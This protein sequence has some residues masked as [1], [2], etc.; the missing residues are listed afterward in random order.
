MSDRMSSATLN[1]MSP[2]ALTRRTILPLCGERPQRYQRQTR[3]Q[4]QLLQQRPWSRR[5]EEK[6]EEG[7]D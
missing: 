2:S 6:E 5:S 3:R 1:M 4:Q 7:E